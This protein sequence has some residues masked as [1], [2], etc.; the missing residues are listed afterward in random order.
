MIQDLVLTPQP[1]RDK[2]QFELNFFGITLFQVRFLEPDTDKLQTTADL[3]S[4]NH[5]IYVAKEDINLHLSAIGTQPIIHL[6]QT[7]L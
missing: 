7:V 1:I 4:H 5:K 6:E 2:R 3:E